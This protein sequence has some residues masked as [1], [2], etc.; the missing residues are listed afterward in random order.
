MRLRGHCIIMAPSRRHHCIQCE[1]GWL[2]NARA[3]HCIF[4]FLARHRQKTSGI[5]S[6][7]R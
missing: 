6:D 1:V 3:R 5:R 7:A 4:E 2:E